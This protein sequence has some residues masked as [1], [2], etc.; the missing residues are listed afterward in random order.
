M[1]N[2]LL[3]VCL[4]FMSVVCSAQKYDFDFVFRCTIQDGKSK[5]DDTKSDSNNAYRVSWDIIDANSISVKISEVKIDNNGNAKIIKNIDAIDLNLSVL[6]F[7]DD[8]GS[9]SIASNTTPYFMMFEVGGLRVRGLSGYTFTIP[10]PVWG[11]TLYTIEDGKQWETRTIEY[12][13]ETYSDL[14]LKLQTLKWGAI[15]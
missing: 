5:L 6:T 3:I 2:I 12:F 7:F 13:K 10:D 8:E 14:K 15:K 11:M 9:F 4:F 1:K